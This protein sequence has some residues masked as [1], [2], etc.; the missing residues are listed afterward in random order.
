MPRSH[1]ARSGVGGA[2][3]RDA[4]ECFWVWDIW[5]DLRKNSIPGIYSWSIFGSFKAL[6]PFRILVSSCPISPES[7]MVLG[8]MK[9]NFVG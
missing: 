7:E 3:A 1:D 8:Q 4:A 9:K 6:D 5:A 2:A